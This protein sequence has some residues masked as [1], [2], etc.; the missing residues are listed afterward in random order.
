[1]FSR[2]LRQSFIVCFASINLLKLSAFALAPTPQGSLSLAWDPSSDPT[3]VGYR[4]Y[5]G[6]ASQVYTN[7]IDVGHQTSMTISNLVTGATYFF[8]VTA[9]DATGSESAF[10]GQIVYT[11]PISASLPGEALL[12]CALRRDYSGHITLSGTAPAGW[13]YD[14]WAT[15]DLVSWLP[16]GSVIVDVTGAFQFTE[17][18]TSLLPVRFYRLHQLSTQPGG[19]GQSQGTATASSVRFRSLFSELPISNLSES[20][21]K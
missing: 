10:S 2:L 14:V 15:Q 17:P 13:S 1:M 7:V 6:G 5:Q 18:E 20:T 9:Y 19:S 21:H 4:V 3:V 12:S 11:V 8:A 16:I